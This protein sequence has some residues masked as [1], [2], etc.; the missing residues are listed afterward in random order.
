MTSRAQKIILAWLNLEAKKVKKTSLI[1]WVH[2]KIEEIENR[3]IE[4]DP[5]SPREKEYIKQINALESK[6]RGILA[7]KSAAEGNKGKTM[8]DLFVLYWSLYTYVNVAKFF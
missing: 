2:G 6:L 1:V 5:V 7:A 4:A 8:D 3:K